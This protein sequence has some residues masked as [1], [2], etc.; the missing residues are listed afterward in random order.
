MNRLWILFLPIWVL[1]CRNNFCLDGGCFQETGAMGLQDCLETSTNIIDFGELMLTDGP[2]TKTLTITDH[3]DF[4]GATIAWTLD[5]PAEVFNYAFE[6]KSAVQIRFSAAIT[7]EWEAQ[8]T[9]VHA[10]DK[11][12]VNV[13]LFAK[14]MVN[15]EGGS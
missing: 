4:D 14:T 15:E 3:C 5:D 8:F 12:R 7:G 10:I 11:N 9:G 2:Q 6:S 13:Q 1:G